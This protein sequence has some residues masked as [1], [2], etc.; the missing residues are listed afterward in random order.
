[1]TIKTQDFVIFMIGVFIGVLLSAVYTPKPNVHIFLNSDDIL[2]TEKSD[3]PYN[4]N[5]ISSQY[6]F[7]EE[8][9]CLTEVIYFEAGNQSFKGK[10]AVGQVVLNRVRSKR[11]P[12]SICKTV[13]MPN[14]FSFVKVKPK[15]N[16][17]KLAWLRSLQAAVQ[18]I[19]AKEEEVLFNKS[20]MH[21]HASYINPPSWTKS[22]ERVIQI[23]DHVFYK[24]IEV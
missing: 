16:F 12:D 11:F 6:K 2:G 18:I 19:S 13:K 9:N 20:V 17:D 3:Q 10:I 22:M 5:H 7:Q 15:Y 14:Q 1:M 24:E 21:F 23:G 8:L 4:I